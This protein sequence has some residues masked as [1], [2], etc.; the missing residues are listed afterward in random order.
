PRKKCSACSSSGAMRIRRRRTP[1]PRRERVS[2]L[3]PNLPM[4]LASL[5]GPDIKQIPRE[6]VAEIASEMSADN[7]AD[8]FSV[9]PQAM[10]D[11][12][13]EALQ[14]VDPEAAQEVRE[15]EK[16]PDTSA[17]HLM[18]PDFVSVTPRMRVSEAF[19]IVKQRARDRNE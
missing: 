5:L 18:T 9:L 6:S 14:R 13:F 3:G 15:I 16:W 10:G 19:E 12:V 8:L 7:R 11:Q 2:S 17:G 1:W 4:R